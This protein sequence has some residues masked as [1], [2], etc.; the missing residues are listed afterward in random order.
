MHDSVKQMVIQHIQA[1]R[2]HLMQKAELKFSLKCE[3]AVN[4]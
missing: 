4:N 2:I 1:N 3:L